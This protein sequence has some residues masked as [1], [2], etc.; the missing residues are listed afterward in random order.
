MAETIKELTAENRALH[1]LVERIERSVCRSVSEYSFRTAAQLDTE[2]FYPVAGKRW[3]K[4]RR[5]AVALVVRAKS[6]EASA[7]AS[8]SFALAVWQTRP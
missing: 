4:T 3:R 5:A 2:G 1:G 7:R 8:R 6:R